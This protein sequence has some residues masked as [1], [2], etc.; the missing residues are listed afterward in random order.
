MNLAQLLSG[1][2][3]CWHRVAMVTLWSAGLDWHNL[4]DDEAIAFVYAWP[5]AQPDAAN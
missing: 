1:V 2:V 5:R 4:T 3:V